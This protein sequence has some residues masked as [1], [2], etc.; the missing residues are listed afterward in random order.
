MAHQ[1]PI[2][3]TSPRH[4]IQFKS[5]PSCK[6]QVWG[7]SYV[8]YNPREYASILDVTFDMTRDTGDANGVPY[9]TAIEQV[10]QLEK[11]VILPTHKKIIINQLVDK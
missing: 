8:R 1:L 7:G 2:M 4:G 6:G 3:C 11:W 10:C 5:I 9:E